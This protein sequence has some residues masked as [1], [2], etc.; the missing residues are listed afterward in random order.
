MHSGVAIDLLA[1]GAGAGNGADKETFREE[2]RKGEASP[3]LRQVPT[4]APWSGEGAGTAPTPPAKDAVQGLEVWVGFGGV[5]WG[6]SGTK[7][8]GGPE[9]GQIDATGE[10]TL[11]QVRVPSPAPPMTHPVALQEE[12]VVSQ[13]RFS[14]SSVKK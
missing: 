3:R 9:R 7:T 10:L 1:L 13:Q 4:A 8:S 14:V 11:G 2:E 6:V 5:G 12:P